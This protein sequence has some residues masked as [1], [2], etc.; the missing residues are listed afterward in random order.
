MRIFNSYCTLILLFSLPVEIVSMKIRRVFILAIFTTGDR[1]GTANLKWRPT[2]LPHLFPPSLASLTRLARQ[3][4]QQPL[5]LPLRS[6]LSLS[7]PA[8][9]GPSTPTFAASPSGSLLAGPTTSTLPA[10]PLNTN[11]TTS[12]DSSSH[13]AVRSR[14]ASWSWIGRSCRWFRHKCI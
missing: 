3:P 10:E 6:F 11:R 9:S 7:W 2:C 4:W 12:G 13:S 14:A 8:S 1:D 5:P